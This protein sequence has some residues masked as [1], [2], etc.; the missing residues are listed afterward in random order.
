MEV[1]K[2]TGKPVLASMCIM[3]TTDD[4]GVPS[5]ECAVRLVKAG[6]YYFSVPNTNP[7]PI[8][9]VYS[10]KQGKWRK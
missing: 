9:D 8:T 5:D 10:S 6:K 2:D 4:K 7:R 3:S 1:L